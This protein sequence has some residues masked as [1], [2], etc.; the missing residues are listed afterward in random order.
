M[1]SPF[2]FSPSYLFIFAILLYT[3]S[4]KKFNVLVVFWK[5]IEIQV[6]VFIDRVSSYLIYS[7]YLLEIL[8]GFLCTQ[9]CYLQI[10]VVCVFFPNLHSFLHFFCLTFFLYTLGLFVGLFIL[11]NRHGVNGYSCL[12]PEFKE[13]ESNISSVRGFWL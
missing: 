5:Y 8:L 1:K 4:L 9:S 3:L 6:I 13:K 2:R 7:T 10:M 11:L 12:I